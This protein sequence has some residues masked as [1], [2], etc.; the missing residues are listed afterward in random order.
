MTVTYNLAGLGISGASYSTSTR[1]DVQI[2]KANQTNQAQLTILMDDGQPLI[3]LGNNNLKLYRYV[4][5]YSDWE[6]VEPTNIESYSDGTYVLD[7]PTG[8]NASS[9]VIQVEDTRGLMVLA[10]SFSQFNSKLTWNTTGFQ[11]G[12]DYVDNTSL[13]AIGTHSNFAAQQSAPDGVYDT[14]TEAANGTTLAPSYPTNYNTLG[15]TTW[16]G[17]PISTSN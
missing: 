10:S 4:Y 8:V 9:Y 5:N 15:S 14:L 17:N 6:L 7:L 2:S 3:N 16:L 12:F 11:T 1:L 13:N